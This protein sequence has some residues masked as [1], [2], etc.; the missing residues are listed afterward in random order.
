[1]NVQTRVEDFSTTRDAE[2]GLFTSSN[3]STR[4]CSREHV[5]Y[6]IGSGPG[7]KK[8]H[9]GDQAV[10]RMYLLQISKVKVKNNV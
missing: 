7:L 2:L 5:D 4:S 10:G 8:G 3:S 1:M 6:D 9:G